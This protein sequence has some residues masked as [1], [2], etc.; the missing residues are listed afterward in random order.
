METLL[1]HSLDHDDE[2][3]EFAD[4][5]LDTVRLGTATSAA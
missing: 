3:M 5:R 4:G 1:A 2:R